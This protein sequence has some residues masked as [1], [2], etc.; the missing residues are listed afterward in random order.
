MSS[1]SPAIGWIMGSI[2]AVTL[3]AL[4]TCNAPVDITLSAIAA[5]L[6][7]GEDP[8]VVVAYL[9]S[10]HRGGRWSGATSEAGARGPFQLSPLWARRFGYELG[11]LDHPVWSASIAVQTMLRA[12]R[13]HGVDWRSTLKCTRRA[14]SR[15]GPVRSWRALEAD[16]R[17]WLDH[18][19]LF[20][21][22][23]S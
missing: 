13:K 1:R 19:R 10:E 21:S 7:H 6:Y 12:R 17:D 20:A 4:S 3:W 9:C 18:D 22:D 23:E 5:S 16:L 8:V 15:C 11:D 14:R 2:F